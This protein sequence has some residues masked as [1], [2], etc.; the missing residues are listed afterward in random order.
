MFPTLHPLN[1]RHIWL[2]YI[3]FKRNTLMNEN[4]QFLILYFNIM[5]IFNR[6]INCCQVRQ[7]NI[8]K[9]YHMFIS[10]TY[11]TLLMAKKMF[12]IMFFKI[13]LK[14]NFPNRTRCNNICLFLWRT[15]LIRYA[16]NISNKT[17]NSKAFYVQ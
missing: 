15:F 16:N 3:H 13:L 2:K 12:S 9:T 11:N 17:D 14:T 10:E 8:C 7:L 6:H 5:T 4:F 1:Y